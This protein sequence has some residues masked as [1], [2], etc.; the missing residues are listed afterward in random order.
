[1]LHEV[2]AVHVVLLSVLDGLPERVVE[3]L[4]SAVRVVVHAEDA[5]QCRLHKYDGHAQLGP[6]RR[7]ENGFAVL[8][9][10]RVRVV[11]GVQFETKRAATDHVRRVLGHHLADFD[12]PGVQ[13]QCP[14]DGRQQT[15]TALL[16]LFVHVLQLVGRER[17][18]ELL[19]HRP[20]P[21]APREEYVVV[22]RVRMRA[23]VQPAV[24]EVV[25]VFDQYVPCMGFD[26]NNKSK[27]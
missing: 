5:Q 21:F 18:T 26:E 11:D 17:G 25:E 8:P 13:T 16:H 24:R 9:E 2:F 4:Y 23:G 6:K 12:A 22:E 15:V 10:L 3:E 19:P 1:M 7:L 20:P 14:A 27:F